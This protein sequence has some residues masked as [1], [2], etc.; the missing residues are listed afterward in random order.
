MTT[1][2]FG[3]QPNHRDFK[4][5]EGAARTA[6]AGQVGEQ[7]A[8]MLGITPQAFYS[9]YHR[10]NLN[11]RPG[12]FD[13]AEAYRTS[14]RILAEHPEI[15][16]VVCLGRNVGAAVGFSPRDPLLTIIRSTTAT[17]GEIERRSY[18]LFPHPSGRNRF[19]NNP[20]NRR[21][22]ARRLREFLR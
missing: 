18:L 4:N 6:C 21:N 9:L 22:A 14:E 16:R 11:A 8:A 7:L 20:L 3:Q 19:W 2:I 10:F 12:P 13:E 17:S 5:V 1:V 15:K